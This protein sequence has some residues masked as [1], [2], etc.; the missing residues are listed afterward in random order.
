MIGL[1]LDYPLV[2]STIIE[3]AAATFGGTEL[4]S[5][6]RTETIRSSYHEAAQRS[7]RLAASLPCLGAGPGG[8]VGSLAWNTHRHLELFYGVSGIGGVLHTANPRLPPDQILYT[9][10][11]TGYQTL[12]IDLDTLALAEQIA[13]HLKTVDRFVLMTSR[14]AMPAT[15]LANVLCYEDLIDTGDPSFAWP[16]LDER[17]ACLLCF[18]S[19]TTGQPKGVLYSHRGTVLSALSVGGGNGW[20]L[21][22]DDV[23]LG[24]PGF[25]HC[26]GWAVPFLAPMYGAK[27]V[28]PG[29]RADDAWLYRL[30]M[31]EGVTIGAGVPTIWLGLLEYCRATGQRLG[32]LRRIFSGG[33]APPAAMIESYLRDHGVRVSHGWG[34]TE[35]THGATISFAKRGLSDDATVTAMRTQGQPLYGNEIRIVDDEDRPLSCDGSIAGHLQCRGHWT[36]GAY[37]KRP[38]LDLLTKDGWMR[39]GDIAVI[40]PDYTLHIVDRAKDVIK[41]GGE[42]ISSQALEEAAMR[43]PAVQEAAVVA[44]QHARWQERPFLI[45]VLTENATVTVDDL[46]LHLLKFVPKWWL[47]DAIAFA[48]ELPHGPTG[49]LQ[50]DELRR[51]VAAGMIAPTKS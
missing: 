37:F 23:V 6:G 20:A 3:H 47:P 38:E 26:N 30:I 51:R 19:G 5:H 9:I 31:D 44:M 13:P 32:S 17:L 24:I 42:W 11:F 16:A 1:N 29:R 10:N 22:A 33:T 45:A 39:T 50:K 35:T 12:F 36:A 43:H 28:L 2:L 34:M 25:F 46:R 49:K 48:T 8:F 15:S 14:D 4:V 41:S 27:L 21:S 40:D 7:R 18:T